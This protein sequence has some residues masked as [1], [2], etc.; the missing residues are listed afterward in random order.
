MVRKNTL[1]KI[2]LLVFMPMLLISCQKHTVEEDKPIPPW[3][4]SGPDSVTLSVTVQTQQGIFMI[5]S[6]VNLALNQDSLNNGIYVRRVST[7]ATGHARFNRLYP[8]KYYSNCFANYQ[9]FSL[10]GSFTIQL[11]P[12]AV[13]DTVL[14]VH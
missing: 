5:G 7:D 6:Y 12:Y 4:N 14:I 3:E 11:P 10:Y 1:L 8:R 9:T 13:R 2:L